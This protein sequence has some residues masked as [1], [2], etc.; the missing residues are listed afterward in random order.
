MNRIRPR[1]KLKVDAVLQRSP[2]A[3]H[4]DLAEMHCFSVADFGLL[5]HS[6]VNSPKRS[7]YIQDNAAL[8]GT[9]TTNLRDVDQS[10]HYPEPLCC[11]CGDVGCLRQKAETT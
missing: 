3:N 10:C 1:A 4:T 6:V 2:A 5:Q 9:S 7:D 11:G 8:V